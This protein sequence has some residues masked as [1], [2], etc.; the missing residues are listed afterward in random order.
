[1][2]YY[3]TNIDAKFV[4]SVIFIRDS[5]PSFGITKNTRNFMLV[6]AKPRKKPVIALPIDQSLKTSRTSIG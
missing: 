4:P 2:Q 5:A 1:M 6:A 3:R